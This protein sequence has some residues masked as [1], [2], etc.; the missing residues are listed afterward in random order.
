MNGFIVLI[1]PSKLNLANHW[2]QS[3][4]FLTVFHGCKGGREARASPA[5]SFTQLVV[6]SF[7]S[8]NGWQRGGEV[9]MK[10]LAT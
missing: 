2:A 3:V 5:N 9:T 7:R 8:N 6:S 1:N 10:K 4:Q